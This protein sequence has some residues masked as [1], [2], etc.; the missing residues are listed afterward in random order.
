MVLV[1]YILG[2]YISVLQTKFSDREG[3]EARRVGLEAMPL[4]QH[5][6]G[7]H[8]EREPRLK[9]RP[10]PVHDF[11]A[12]ADDGQHRQDRLDE[13]AILP[14]AALTQCEVGGVALGRMEG[15]IAQDNHTAIKLS[16]EPLKG[17]IRNVGGGTRHPTINPHWFSN[18]HS[19]PP[20][21]Q[22]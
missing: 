15:G 4:N 1:S 5:I 19:L 6:E 11:L 8:G 21:I 17:V 10:D 18:K 12:V 3:H 2:N 20:T 22:R 14:R 9:I 13:D 7:R 16:N